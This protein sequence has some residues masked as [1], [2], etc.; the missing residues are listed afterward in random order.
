MIDIAKLRKVHAMTCSP[1]PHEAA[2]AWSKVDGI[3]KAGGKTRRAL[4]GLLK[5]AEPPEPAEAAGF[6][7]FTGFDDWMEKQEPGYRARTAR[8]RAERRQR[9]K[10][11]L[12]E[13]LRLYGSME[14][15]QADNAMQAAVEA[16]AAPFK[17]KVKHQFANGVF[18]MD[19]LDGWYDSLFI[20]RAPERVQAAIARA[21]PMPVTVTEAKAEYDAWEA[22]DRE[23]G[24]AWDR[25]DDTQLS[26]PCRIRQEMV[27][28]LFERGL[29]SRTL[30][31]VLL[32][33]RYLLDS[34]SGLGV[35]EAV[36][37]DLEALAAKEAP[38]RPAGTIPPE[39]DGL[40]APR[41][42]PKEQAIGWARGWNACREAM[43]KGAAAN[44]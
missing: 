15:L 22:R 13:L 8:E 9:E 18:E 34:N 44:G 43:M 39:V 42:M 31:E 36:L 37:A 40:D 41:G 6:N 16:A 17:G 33:Q 11:E 12:A 30:D 4:P 25:L 3:L 1:N 21:L 2:V 20:D 32:R 5:E 27:R 38:P 26:L 14:A 23:L 35:E 29:R 19:G 10:D 28:K 24:L 7:P